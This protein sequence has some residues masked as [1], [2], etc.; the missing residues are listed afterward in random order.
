MFTFKRYRINS[1]TLRNIREKNYRPE[2]IQT[3]HASYSP[4]VAD[5]ANF[6]FRRCQHEYQIRRGLRRVNVALSSEKIMKSNKI[7]KGSS[8]NYE[9]VSQSDDKSEIII[10]QTNKQ[11]SVSVFRR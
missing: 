1:L 10:F 3:R 9:P 5:N 8:Q 2:Q 6:S 4:T 7:A 11:I